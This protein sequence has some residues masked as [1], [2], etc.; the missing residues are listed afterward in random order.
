LSGQ[1]DESQSIFKSPRKHTYHILSSISHII[2]GFTDPAIMWINSY[3]SNRTQ[4]VFFNG[5]LSNIIQVESGIPQGR[6]LGHLFF[7]YLLTSCQCVCMYVDD[8]ALYTSATEMTA[9]LR[10]AV[11]F[12]TGSKE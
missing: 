12:R 4:S 6:C 10:A 8:S 9:T 3:L 1:I 5:S 2:Q 11:S 7:K